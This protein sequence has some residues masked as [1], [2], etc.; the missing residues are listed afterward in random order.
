MGI[1]IS[2]TRKNY[3]QRNNAVKPLS[4]CNVTSMVM[5]L[6]YLGYSFPNGTYQQPEDNL[7]VFIE[8]HGKDP[9][10]HYVLSEYTNKW[11][12]R[13][14]TRFSTERAIEAIFTELREGRP[15]V[16]SGTFPGYP[17]PNVNRATGKKEPLGHIVCLVGVEFKNKN[18]GSLPDS[19][20]W[21]DPYGNTLQNWKGSGD[22]IS[23]AYQTFIDWIKPCGDTRYKWGH[24]FITGETQ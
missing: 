16:V 24:F 5:A 23:V 17:E 22:D 21:D 2:H 15:V 10:N 14:V 1:N 9:T 3:S 20:L 11:M 18:S 7:R 8:R 6:D 13:G 12:G 4:S 19:V